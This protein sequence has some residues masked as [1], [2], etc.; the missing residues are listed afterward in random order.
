AE[1][2][3]QTFEGSGMS[4]NLPT[5]EV[6]RAE[7]RQGLGVLAAFTRVGLTTSNGDARRQVAGGGLRVN[8]EAVIDDKLMLT[9]GHLTGDGVIKL[10]LGRK[11]HV[12][13]RAV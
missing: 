12:L 7:L 3:R 11:K 4:A 1:T 8:D 10:S 5:V 6:P 13:L 9:E 2:S